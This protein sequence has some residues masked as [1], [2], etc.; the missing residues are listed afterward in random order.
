MGFFDK[1]LLFFAL[2]GYTGI[3]V[4]YCLC[5]FF[6]DVNLGFPRIIS[7][8]TG[9][10]VNILIIFDIIR[11]VVKIIIMSKFMPVSVQ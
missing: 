11:A 1:L 6:A 2:S 7:D 9:L 5:Y 4:F 10:I 8:S 3:K